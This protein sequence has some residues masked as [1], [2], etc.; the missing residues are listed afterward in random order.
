MNHCGSKEALLTI[1]SSGLFLKRIDGYVTHKTRFFS[2]SKLVLLTNSTEFVD[3]YLYSHFGFLIEKMFFGKN[4]IINIE[5][6]Q[7]INIFLIAPLMAVVSAYVGDIFGRRFVI[8]NSAMVMAL[9]S[10]GV[11]L[12]PVEIWPFLSACLLLGLRIVQGLAMSAE[13]MACYLYLMEEKKNIRDVAFYNCV[14]SATEGI[15]AIIALAGGSCVLYFLGEAYWRLIFILSALSVGMSWVIRRSLAEST[16]YMDRLRDAKIRYDEHSKIRE[17]FYLQSHEKWTLVRNRIAG[18]LSFLAYPTKLV[19]C[20]FYLTPWICA[21]QGWG[22]NGIILWNI[23][24]TFSEHA[25]GCSLF[26]VVCHKTRLPLRTVGREL[27]L[28]G[29]GIFSY[30]LWDL[31]TMPL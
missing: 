16:E 31:E 4:F 10:V 9:A 20:F 1:S 19:F 18:F 3:F 12:L 14:V 13:P 27:Y 21:R 24:L 26:Y 6:F 17:Y 29:L 7:W 30:V 2:S 23:A 11:I 25:I 15:G 8:V 28:L 5:T 22:I